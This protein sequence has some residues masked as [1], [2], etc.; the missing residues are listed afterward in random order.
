MGSAIYSSVTIYIS[1]SPGVK[2]VWWGWTNKQMKKHREGI[3]GVFCILPVIWHNVIHCTHQGSYTLDHNIGVLEAGMLQYHITFLGVL[4][5]TVRRRRCHWQT[6]AL[7]CNYRVWCLPVLNVK[8]P[9]LLYTMSSTGIVI[10]ATITSTWQW[11]NQSLHYKL[12][13]YIIFWLRFV[14]CDVIRNISV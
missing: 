12:S 1:M 10:N 7:Y 8:S 9:K 5:L 6:A 2:G 4:Q 11:A 13:K 3:K 14:P